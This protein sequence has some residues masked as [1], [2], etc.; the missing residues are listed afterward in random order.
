MADD[1]ETLSAVVDDCLE[2]LVETE[3]DSQDLLKE[4]TLE[5]EE[6]KEAEINE[7]MAIVNE[8]AEFIESLGEIIDGGTAPVLSGAA[9][10]MKAA[11]ADYM[12]AQRTSPKDIYL[13]RLSLIASRLER[14][15][16]RESRKARRLQ[17]ALDDLWA[18]SQKLRP[19]N[20]TL[21]FPIVARHGSCSVTYRLTSTAKLRPATSEPV[22]KERLHYFRAHPDLRV[23]FT[24]TVPVR[25]SIESIEHHDCLPCTRKM[26]VRKLR[27][28]GGRADADIK[29]DWSRK[30]P[31]A[32]LTV[33]LSWS[34]TYVTRVSMHW[35]QYVSRDSVPI[36]F[37]LFNEGIM[38]DLAVVLDKAF[39][40]WRVAGSEEFK[41]DLPT[42]RGQDD[43]SAV[44]EGT[45]TGPSMRGLYVFGPVSGVGD[46]T[47]ILPTSE[48]A[49]A[50]L[51]VT[52]A[53]PG[54]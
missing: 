22:K 27:L 30:H 44:F 39:G 13:G 45:A 8:W 4:Y 40:A 36:T 31:A 53:T 19:S 1:C 25:L 6:V 2:E 49:S 12:S 28:K 48:E 15:L 11:A 17:A 34:E 29:M 37:D 18:C 24:A 23:S 33:R 50:L 32:S 9:D 3:Q 42:P 51:T 47:M 26:C 38:L 41:Y 43:W 14:S 35:V 16:R 54:G 21:D 10:L 46:P 52:N 20:V 7:V 5:V